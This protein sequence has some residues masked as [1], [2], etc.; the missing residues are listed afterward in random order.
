MVC[1]RARVEL[2]KKM[3]PEVEIKVGAW[4]GKGFNASRVERTTIEQT[5][6]EKMSTQDFD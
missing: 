3:R 5:L 2:K 6:S 4:K 1:G